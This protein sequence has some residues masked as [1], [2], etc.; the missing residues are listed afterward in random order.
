[1]RGGPGKGGG[2]DVH[3]CV[4]GAPVPQLA[5]YVAERFGLRVPRCLG[6]YTDVAETDP[7]ERGKV[8][9]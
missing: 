6:G 2:I 4:P 9:G 7:R 5:A 1:M 3:T 8:W